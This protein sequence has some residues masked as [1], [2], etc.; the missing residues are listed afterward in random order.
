MGKILIIDDNKNNL[1]TISATLE[2]SL[3]GYSVITATGASD[4]IALARDEKPDVILL[5]IIMPDIDGFEACRILKSDKNTSNIPIVLLT[6]LLTNTESKIKGLDSGADAFL[7]KP[8]DPTELVAQVKAMIR[9][10]KAEIKLIRNAVKL[11]QKVNYQAKLIV[12]T[13]EDYKAL[14]NNIGEGIGKLDENNNFV[15]LNKKGAEIFGAG[16]EELLNTNIVNLFF[17][18]EQKALNDGLS[19]ARGSKASQFQL[20]YKTKKGNAKDLFVT[21]MSEFDSNGIYTGL[22]CIFRDISHIVEHERML[23]MQLELAKALGQADTLA[24]TAGIILDF[25]LSTKEIDGSSLYIKNNNGDFLLLAAKGKAEVVEKRYAKF[26][27]NSAQGILANK[28]KPVYSKYSDIPDE[29]KLEGLSTIPKFVGVIPVLISGETIAVLNVG[30]DGYDGFSSGTIKLVEYFHLQLGQKLQQILLKNEKIENE[31][32]YRFLFEGNKDAL[33]TIKGRVINSCNEALVRMLNY[34]SK[35]D[36]IGKSP[37]SF[38]PNRKIGRFVPAIEGSK[39]IKETLRQGSATFEWVLQ[40][41]DGS[42]FW[43]EA[44]LSLVVINDERVIYA[45]LRDLT[46]EKAHLEEIRKFKLTTDQAN[47]GCAMADME[48]KIIYCNEYFAKMH[49]YTPFEITGKS[50]R[51]LY[52]QEQLD[53]MKLLQKKILADGHYTN[54]EVYHTTKGGKEMPTLMNGVLM[55]DEFGKPKY[56]TCTA[57]DISEIKA[58]H[59]N[60]ETALARA[61]ESDHLKNAFLASISHEFRTPLNAIIGFSQ[62]I[63]KETSPEQIKVYSQLIMDSGVSLL[64][65]VKDIFYFTLIRSGQEKVVKEQAGVKSILDEVY[66][67]GREIQQASNKTGIKFKL[68]Y[69]PNTVQQ[70]LNTDKSKL[71]YVFK[72]LLKNAF[73]FTIDGSVEIGYT[74]VKNNRMRFYVKDTGVGIPDDKKD[75]IFKFFRQTEDSF[76][77]RFGGVGIGLSIAR[78]L[79]EMLGGTISVDSVVDKGSVFYFTIPI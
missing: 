31:V 5:D 47:Y 29:L 53:I 37:I 45:T 65:I 72:L 46:N 70:F 49:G 28:G 77:R 18:D 44:R 6:A 64:E 58:Y 26:A 1:L 68:D 56:V 55:Y 33:L 43:V 9:I 79:V 20:V 57:I 48:G 4:G 27:R 22:S 39:A 51:I 52:S 59:K 12:E 2:N 14:F 25:T 54:E 62:L 21:T 17:E 75:I 8:F 11:E 76:T 7:T 50:F 30:T 69:P 34:K 13:N 16:I 35:D 10:K 38:S 60:L 67:I 41:S 32:R 71:V 66:K 78:R 19:K 24:E 63:A 15:Y 74:V 40:K 73:K 36:I 42:I 61:E 3:P 23:K